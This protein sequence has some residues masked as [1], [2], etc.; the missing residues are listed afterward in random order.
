MVSEKPST[1]RAC[2]GT[3][4][5]VRDRL[6]AV[7]DGGLRRP[8][9]RTCPRR[10]RR[11]R[12][13]CRPPSREIYAGNVSCQLFL[14]GSQHLCVA[15]LV[16]GCRPQAEFQDARG[17][18]GECIRDLAGSARR[19][20][21]RDGNQ[22]GWVNEPETTTRFLRAYASRKCCRSATCHRKRVQ[23]SKG[24]EWWRWT[25]QPPS[26]SR[27]SAHATTRASQVVPS[28]PALRGRPDTTASS[29][30]TVSGVWNG[31]GR[32]AAQIGVC[33]PIC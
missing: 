29:I 33:T 4:S 26:R 13:P 5:G 21:R 25:G 22:G 27:L 9:V 11:P 7:G 32:E 18:R 31:G 8:S 14:T 12:Q 10:P 3:M 15:S 20:G 16:A 6:A 30:A 23:R 28:A 1:R 19:S 24:S 17:F 2:L